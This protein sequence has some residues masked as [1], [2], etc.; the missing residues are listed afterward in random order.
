MAHEV[1]IAGTIQY[2]M[3]QQSCTTIIFWQRA[4]QTFLLFPRLKKTVDLQWTESGVY[5][6]TYTLMIT[7]NLVSIMSWL[8]VQIVDDWITDCTFF[9]KV[10]QNHTHDW[11]TQKYELCTVIHLVSLTHWHPN[12]ETTIYI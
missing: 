2:V 7:N 11:S 4:L 5:C 6:F 12:R 9:Y 8:T 3:N 10:M 1:K